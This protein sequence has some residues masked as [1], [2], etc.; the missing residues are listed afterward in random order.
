MIAV[1]YPQSPV[2]PSNKPRQ[3]VERLWAA[4]VDRHYRVIEANPPAE[5]RGTGMA[6]LRRELDVLSREFGDWLWEVRFPGDDFGEGGFGEDG[7]GGTEAAPDLSPL[8]EAALAAYQ[9]YRREC[10][11]ERGFGETALPGETYHLT[12]KREALFAAFDALER[13]TQP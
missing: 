7:F 2:P 12:T 8:T 13:E 10:E 3:E 11:A 1:S 5:Y 9:D 6:W 4:L